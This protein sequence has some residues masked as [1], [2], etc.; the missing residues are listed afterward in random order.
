[1]LIKKILSS[2]LTVAGLLIVLAF[3]SSL[4][5]RQ[6]QARMAVEKEKQKIIRQAS[7]LQQKN[8]NLRASLD[9]LSSAAAKERAAR[10]KLNLKKEGEIVYNFTSN[11]AASSVYAKNI[12][13]SLSNPEKWWEYFT[14]YQ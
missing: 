10:E 13:K 2:K 14:R 3:L 12:K 4:K 8:E 5:F 11:A 9:Y 1:M 7:E 6:W